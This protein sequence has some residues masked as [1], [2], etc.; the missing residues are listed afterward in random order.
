M[1]SSAWSKSGE[2]PLRRFKN[3]PFLSFRP[4]KIPKTATAAAVSI[5]N[6]SPWL[7]EDEDTLGRPIGLAG[8][9]RA[10]LKGTGVGFW[11]KK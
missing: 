7:D 2:C 1:P 4:R 5:P 10:N 8:E 11:K 6:N 9:P 3:R